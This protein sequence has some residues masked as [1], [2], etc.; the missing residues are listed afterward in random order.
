VFGNSLDIHSVVRDQEYGNLE[1]FMKVQN[2]LAQSGPHGSIK[3]APGLVKQE[4]TWLG[5]E[6]AG[7]SYALLLTTG[8]LR[9]P[10]L[11]QAGQLHQTNQFWQAFTRRLA[12][13]PLAEGDVLLNRKM[14]KKRVLL[15]KIADSARLG[16]DKNACRTLVPGLAA[17]HN[18]STFQRKQ[19]RQRLQGQTL[20]RPGGSKQHGTPGKSRKDDIQT[21]SWQAA[22]ETD[23]QHRLAI[24]CGS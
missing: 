2:L 16:R 19:A 12:A 9:W 21:K 8:E 5:S 10:G 7:Q 20:A 24:T 14:R 11:F 18:L 4:Q 13:S 15:G 3:R 17:A 23:A 1:L 6:G 22:L